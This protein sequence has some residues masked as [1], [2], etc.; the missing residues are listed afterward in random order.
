MTVLAEVVRRHQSAIAAGSLLSLMD[1]L[2]FKAAAV[3]TV[4]YRLRQEGILEAHRDGGRAT[5]TVTP[6][7][8]RR[9]EAGNRRTFE[10]YRESWDG[11]WRILTYNVPE[12]DRKLRDELRS[13]L[14]WLGFGQLT[15]ST[16]I[17]P[18][19]VADYVADLIRAYQMQPYVQLF[20]ARHL[21][22]VSSQE[23]VRQAWDLHAV[24]KEYELF[25]REGR[26]RW[27]E[28][29]RSGRPLTDAEAFAERIRLVSR[30]QSFLDIDPWLPL[31]LL[32]G[33]W[34]GEEA[35]RLFWAYY[36]ELS[37]QADHFLASHA[38]L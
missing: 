19:R 28:L 33:N 13:D 16:W 11:Y 4:I 22:L 17:S 35:R 24:G 15:V 30:Y 26:A 8:M 1:T 9:L 23:L 27:E 20:E 10:T 2:G 3:R 21:G 12:R 14:T 25:I 32:P 6:A 37:P 7:G 36:L 29:L 31:E 5:Y 38:N 34:I 18:R